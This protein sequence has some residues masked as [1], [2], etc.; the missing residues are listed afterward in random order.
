LEC[1]GGIATDSP[2]VAAGTSFAALFVRT[3]DNA[4]WQKTVTGAGAGAWS[5]LPSGASATGPAAVV[6][7][8]DVVHLVVRGTDGAVYHAT[9]RGTTW[10]GWE[11]LGGRIEGTPAVAP[12]TGGGIAIIV[13]GIDN[14]IYAKY[15]DTRA[16]TGWSGLTGETLSSPAVA[17]GAQPGRLDVF[18]AGTGG[19]LY[20]N[21]FLNGAW[22]GWTRLDALAATARVAAAAGGG[23]IIVYTTTGGVTSYKQHLGGWR[24]YKPAPYTCP[25]CLPRLRSGPTIG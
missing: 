5:K 24:S 21:V 6:T 10:S 17:W 22:L 19:G 18:V 12:R 3:A 20:H 8:G 7:A 13:R 16:W 9:R 14:R 1:L 15:G 25:T 11:G 4:L 23:R 2:A